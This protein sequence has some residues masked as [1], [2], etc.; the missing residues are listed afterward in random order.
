VHRLGRLR[1]RLHLPPA[2]LVGEFHRVY[3]RKAGGR[4]EEPITGQR[5]AAAACRRRPAPIASPAPPGGGEQAFGPGLG[6]CASRMRKEGRVG[7]GFE[8]VTHLASRSLRLS[9]VPRQI[10]HACVEAKTRRS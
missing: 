3:V 9:D 6:R 5:G 8:R 2:D 10:V 7:V 4:G 1:A